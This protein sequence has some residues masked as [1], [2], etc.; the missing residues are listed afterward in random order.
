MPVFQ[1]DVG[2]LDP[3]EEAGSCAWL[4]LLSHPGDQWVER[5][6][7]LDPEPEETQDSKFFLLSCALWT[8]TQAGH[9]LDWTFSVSVLLL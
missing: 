6:D 4:P 2:S 3:G 8:G 7:L 1:R 5:W 9:E